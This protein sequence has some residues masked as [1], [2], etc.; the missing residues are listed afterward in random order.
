MAVVKQDKDSTA[1]FGGRIFFLGAGFSAAAGV[2]LTNVLLPKALRLMRQ[3]IPDFYE[4]MCQYARDIDLD[5]NGSPDA[6]KFAHLCTYLDFL[7]LREHGGSER[8]SDRGSRE[9]LCLNFFLA[10]AI[11]HS[12]PEF[13]EIPELYRKFVD[14]IRYPDIVVT[15]NWDTL[16][17]NAFDAAGVPFSY[18][19]QRGTVWLIKLH[20][21]VN[22]VFG[23]HDPLTNTPDDLGFEKI[24]GDFNTEGLDIFS[25]PKLR[26]RSSW[27][28]LKPLIHGID[29]LIVL[30]GYG[31]SFDVRKLS[32]LWYKIEHVSVQQG[33]IFIIGLRVSDDDFIMEGLFRYLFRAAFKS[34]RVVSVMN[35]DA[36]VGTRFRAIAG[37]HL[38]M[39]FLEA[40]FCAD[41]IDGLLA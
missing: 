2:P 12:T 13:T 26:M 15:F 21:S 25:I 20:G 29:P 22:W 4:R 23:R 3:E 27:E 5:L 6:T 19:F 33:P 38:S 35:P 40:K 24:L 34:T 14:R 18:D 1:Y 32:D 7:E 16:L 39:R 41:T 10:K 17:E 28:S 11:A 30:P 37:E 36:E 31:K 9:R 8:W